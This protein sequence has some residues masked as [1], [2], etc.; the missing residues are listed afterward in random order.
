MAWQGF[1]AAKQ[2]IEF[3]APPSFF[4]SKKWIKLI[5]KTQSLPLHSGRGSSKG[6]RRK[7][8]AR[9]CG[10]RG[11]SELWRAFVNRE[12]SPAKLDNF[13]FFYFF[14]EDAGENIITANT[15]PVVSRWRSSTVFSSYV[16]HRPNCCAVQ[17]TP[18]SIVAPTRSF[19]TKQRGDHS[20]FSSSPDFESQI[21]IVEGA[22]PQWTSC[23][24]HQ[25]WKKMSA[26][27][28]RRSRSTRTRG[29]SARHVD[30]A[31]TDQFT[32]HSDRGAI[33]HSFVCL[34]R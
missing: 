29:T 15:L 8:L 19:P 31:E 24:V 25:R 32:R 22:F 3:P 16:A 9:T 12:S 5:P 18:S 4:S 2:T 20:L 33:P 30:V 11:G 10:G 1:E 23:T 28:R 14:F 17:H 6:G 13:A 7:G 26:P 34:C 21:E 27:S